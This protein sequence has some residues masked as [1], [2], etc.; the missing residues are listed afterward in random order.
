M[1]TFHVVRFSDGYTSSALFPWSCHTPEVLQIALLSSNR[2]QPL[3]DLCANSRLYMNKT[4]FR[5]KFGRLL[6]RWWGKR[7][8]RTQTLT[9]SIFKASSFSEGY[10]HVHGVYMLNLFLYCYI[11]KCFTSTPS[12]S[13]MSQRPGYTFMVFILGREMLAWVM[14]SY[15]CSGSFSCAAVSGLQS[16]RW[17][18]SAHWPFVP[19]DVSIGVVINVRYWLVWFPHPPPQ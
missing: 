4:V 2:R 9:W 1:Y 6:P 11:C 18:H 16:P 12:Q 13:H 14:C 8:L 15:V 7:S 3:C 10:Y 5:L 19:G 17:F